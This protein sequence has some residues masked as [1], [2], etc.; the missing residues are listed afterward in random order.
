MS[1]LHGSYM[2]TTGTGLH[3]DLLDMSCAWRLTRWQ[4]GIEVH[5]VNWLPAEACPQRRYQ[6]QASQCCNKGDCVGWQISKQGSV[7]LHGAEK[8]T[9]AK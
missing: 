4:E 9:A 2:Y 3:S 5:Q 1:Q 7:A 8:G 6:D